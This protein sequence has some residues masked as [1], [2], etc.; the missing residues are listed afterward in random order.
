MPKDLVPAGS[1]IIHFAFLSIA[2]L[3]PAKNPYK[4]AHKPRKAAFTTLKYNFC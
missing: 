1:K 2:S 4:L 3:T